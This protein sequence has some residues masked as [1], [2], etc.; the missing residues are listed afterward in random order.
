M[1]ILRKNQKDRKFQQRFLNE[2]SQMDLLRNCTSQIIIIRS[3]LHYLL[4]QNKKIQICNTSNTFSIVLEI[5]F[6]T[7]A[8]YPY[9]P[10]TKLIDAVLR[11]QGSRRT[12][13]EILEH[14]LS[15]I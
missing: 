10:T 4:I 5:S 11:P 1:T 14:I 2:E 12:T 3:F 9:L 6:Y 7:I 8:F 13:H 15:N